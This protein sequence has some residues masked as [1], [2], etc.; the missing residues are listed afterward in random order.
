MNIAFTPEGWED[1]Q[2]WL[3]HD[4]RV[5]KRIHELIKDIVRS[6][7]EGIG[8]PE[9]LKYHLSGCWSRRLTEE[10]RVVYRPTETAIVFLQFRYHYH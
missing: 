5:L 1:C 3:K 4:K 10:H 2:Y 7:F 8:K 6:P 9:P